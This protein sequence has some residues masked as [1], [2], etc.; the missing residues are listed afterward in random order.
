MK[1][2]LFW[3]LWFVALTLG[4]LTIGGSIVGA[5]AGSQVQATS[6]SDGY[7]KGHDV[8]A[9][10]GAEF[11]RDYAG[12]ILLGALVLSIAGTAFGVLPGTKPRKKSGDDT[13]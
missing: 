13:A 4:G 8:G 10:A 12:L 6:I 5:I 7:K 3:F 1:R 2:A 11:G 9:V